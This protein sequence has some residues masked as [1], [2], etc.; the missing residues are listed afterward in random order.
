MNVPLVSVIIP[1]YNYGRFLSDAIQ[2]ALGQSYPNLEVIVVDD[3]STDNSAEIA[4]RFGTQIK[5]IE[6]PNAGVSAARNRGISESQGALVAFLD[7]DDMWLPTKIE[8]QVRAF[9]EDPQIGLVHCGY[10]ELYEDGSFGRT[11]LDGLSGHVALELLRYQ[12]P[13]ILGGGSATVVKRSVCRDVGGFDPNVSPAEDW[14]FYYRCSKNTKVG[15]IKEPLVKYREHQNNAHLNV[16]RMEKAILGAFD[17]AFAENGPDLANIRNECYG[18]I[19]SVLAGSYFRAGMYGHFLR[20]ALK[21]IWLSPSNLV[22]FVMFPFRRL[23]NQS[24]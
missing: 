24:E 12:R 20:H 1:N 23:Q 5:L 15:F 22:R 19:H 4:G 10:V 16:P 14:E 11:H 3:G 21:S 2:S 7:S 17:K 9:D 8:K 13:V 6:Q 18:K